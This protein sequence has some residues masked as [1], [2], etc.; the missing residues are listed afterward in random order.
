MHN[1]LISYFFTLSIIEDA[2]QSFV[3]FQFQSFDALIGNNSCYLTSFAVFSIARMR[4]RDTTFDLFIA[5]SLQRISRIKNQIFET[6]KSRVVRSS[7]EDACSFESLLWEKDLVLNLPIELVY[8]ALSFAC[9]ISKKRTLFNFEEIDYT[10]LL[11]LYNNKLQIEI[12]KKSCIKLVKH[13]QKVL[14]YLN[15]EF[16]QQTLKSTPHLTSNWAKYTSNAFILQD[17]RERLCTPSLYTVMTI[18]DILAKQPGALC[19]LQVNL[20]KNPDIFVS[21]FTLY[22]EVQSTGEFTL[23][24]EEKIDPVFP[25][26]MFAGCRYVPNSVEINIENTKQEFRQKCLRSL[27]FAHEVTYPQYPKDLKQENIKPDEPDLIALIDQFMKLSGFSLDDPSDLCLVHIY[28][29]N[30]ENQSLA[31]Y[32][33]PI[34]LPTSKD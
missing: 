23:V 25:V 17:Q 9:N 12:K 27:I 10:H 31:V 22:F 5:T 30:A 3:N 2:L 8:L 11:N 6:L 33:P 24:E 16:L 28:V 1:N 32:E 14:S 19:G 21:R 20:I 29:D 18:L 26:Y 13:W 15:V 4:T 7:G 34:Y